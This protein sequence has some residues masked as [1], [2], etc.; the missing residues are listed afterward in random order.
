MFLN[1]IYTV[2]TAMIQR[3]AKS[4]ITKKIFKYQKVGTQILKIEFKMTVGTEFYILITPGS[5]TVYLKSNDALHY[6]DRMPV[7]RLSDYIVR[8]GEYDKFI[9][10][11]IKS[12]EDHSEP[13][14]I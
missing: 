7:R 9:E 2:L 4:L 5:N 13:P 8:H 14:K 10:K 1:W 6:P 12:I 3:I 11:L